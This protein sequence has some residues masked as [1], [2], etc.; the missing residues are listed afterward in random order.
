MNIIEQRIRMYVQ[1][2][3]ISEAGGNE[4]G[5]DIRIPGTMLIGEP[6]DGIKRW[7]VERINQ[8]AIAAGCQRGF[9]ILS[10]RRFKSVSTISNNDFNRIIVLPFKCYIFI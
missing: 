1:K 5:Y 9:L 10:N 3:L 7:R 8:Q 6:E 2:L 4:S